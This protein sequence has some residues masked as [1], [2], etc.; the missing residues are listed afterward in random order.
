M[1]IQKVMND[2]DGRTGEPTAN[3]YFDEATDLI[4]IPGF[5]PFRNSR[6]ISRGDVQDRKPMERM[7]RTSDFNTLTKLFR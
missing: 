5:V 3:N 1:N 6:L 2:D 7:R 4:L